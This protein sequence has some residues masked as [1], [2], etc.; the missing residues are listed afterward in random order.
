MSTDD[1]KAQRL[2]SALLDRLAVHEREGTLPT[3][4]RFLFYELVQLGIVPKTRTGVRRADQDMIDALT[5]LREK[6]DVP[7]DWIEDETRKVDQWQTAPSVAEYVADAARN[8]SLDR[9]DGAPAPLILCESRSLAGALNNLAA[10]Y[11]CPIAS[12]NGQAKGFLIVKVAPMMGPGRRVLYIGD[13]DHSGHQIEENNR[14]T[15]SGAAAHPGRRATTGAVMT[16]IPLH[17]VTWADKRGRVTV[18]M[19]VS[20]SVAWR[21]CCALVAAGIDAKIAQ[22]GIEIF[23]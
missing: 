17:T 1:G 16:E 8:A 13:F 7:W 19:Y 9:W 14:D 20:D 21:R 12:T 6:G 18:E 2:R 11:A 3:S 15:L 10:T 4:A 5:Q 23:A 22:Q